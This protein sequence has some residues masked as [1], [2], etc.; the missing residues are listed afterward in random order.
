[1]SKSVVLED[2]KLNGSV[3]SACLPNLPVVEK[4]QLFNTEFM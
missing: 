3:S 2:L 4:T 1:M